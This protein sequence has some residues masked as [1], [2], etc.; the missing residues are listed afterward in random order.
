M[1]YNADAFE[2][3]TDVPWAEDRVRNGIAAI[4]AD[5][6]A[7][8]DPDELWPANEWDAWNSTPPAPQ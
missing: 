1:L 2:P 7:H 5:V 3:L 4:V 8:F 6:D